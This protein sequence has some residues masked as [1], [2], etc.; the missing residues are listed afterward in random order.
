MKFGLCLTEQNGSFPVLANEMTFCPRVISEGA[1]ISI[2]WF[3][4]SYGINIFPIWVTICVLWWAETR[5]QKAF[6]DIHIVWSW[7]LKLKWS[8]IAMFYEVE[9]VYLSMENMIRSS[10]PS[11][12]W[13]FWNWPL[14]AKF[15][16]GL[17][18]PKK[19]VSCIDQGDDLLDM[20]KIGRGTP[21]YN[22]VIWIWWILRFV[23]LSY[24][25]G[26][27]AS[28]NCLLKGI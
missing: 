12:G 17:T 22:T 3:Y 23:Y 2:M 11:C 5:L 15:T 7:V 14:H 18:N 21:S 26:I 27:M 10:D 20:C 8:I 16:L 1:S 13:D 19:Q 24:R 4:Y 6:R 28:W 25:L 9:Q